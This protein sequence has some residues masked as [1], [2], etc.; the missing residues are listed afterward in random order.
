MIFNINYLSFSEIIL[1][2]Q[3]FYNIIFN[4]LF[5]NENIWRF[6]D[7]PSTSM[8]MLPVKNKVIHQI[9]ASMSTVYHK[10]SPLVFLLRLN[11][12]CHSL[13]SKEMR[14]LLKL[15]ES[16]QILRVLSIYKEINNRFPSM[17]NELCAKLLK[18]FLNNFFI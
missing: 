9:A 10:I 15:I 1:S 11:P 4:I 6:I 7:S 17:I 8:R 16:H 13:I 18:K 2:F 14:F 5:W 12:S 3:S